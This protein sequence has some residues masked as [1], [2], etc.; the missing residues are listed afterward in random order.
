[1]VLGLGAVFDAASEPRVVT[2]PAHCM[3]GGG[4]H[5]IDGVVAEW[6]AC[7]GADES[8]LQ[9]RLLYLV[10]E[11]VADVAM[12]QAFRPATHRAKDESVWCDAAKPELWTRVD[13]PPFAG[14]SASM[15]FQCST[16]TPSVDDH[17]VLVGW[18]ADCSGVHVV[19]SINVDLDQVPRRVAEVTGVL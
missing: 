5:M 1:M 4:A 15:C 9:G 3:A 6:T 11:G 17:N 16:R 8:F 13:C 14:A 19:R 10:G 12:C 7:A 2:E 18:T